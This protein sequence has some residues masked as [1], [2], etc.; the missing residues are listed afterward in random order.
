MKK[1]LFLKS[2]PP[3]N[4]GDRAV[5]PDEISRRLVDAGVARYLPEKKA[6]AAKNV[7][8]PPED[9]MMRSAEVKKK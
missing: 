7:E 2:N 9:K 6:S 5:F 4:M 3:Y 1:I 8:A